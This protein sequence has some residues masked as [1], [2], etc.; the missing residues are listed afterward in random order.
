MAT[1]DKPEAA[2]CLVFCTGCRVANEV[3]VP[4]AG[5]SREFSVTCHACSARSRLILESADASLVVGQ[6]LHEWTIPPPPPLPKLEPKPKSTVPPKKRKKVSANDEDELEVLQADAVMMDD[7]DD[8][9]PPAKAKSLK[10]KKARAPDGAARQA[11]VIKVGSA[12]IA[13]HADGYYYTADVDTIKVCC[14]HARSQL[15]HTRCPQMIMCH[16]HAPL[17][18]RL[19]SVACK[20]PMPDACVWRRRGARRTRAASRW[21]GTTAISPFGL[22]HRMLCSPSASRCPWS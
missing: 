1:P 3:P 6:G 4:V 11:A 10:A 16:A 18:A 15:H 14:T 8:S 7:E 9:K 22:A 17:L 5:M 21:R 20:S 13:R 2:Y 19:P 12:V